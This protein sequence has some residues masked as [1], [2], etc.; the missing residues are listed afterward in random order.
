MAIS[1]NMMNLVL[2]TL[3][4]RP[5]FVTTPRFRWRPSKATVVVTRMIQV[6]SGQKRH[7]E[8]SVGNFKRNS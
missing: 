3:G 4:Y 1:M 7:L 6:S 5:N 2:S 8:C